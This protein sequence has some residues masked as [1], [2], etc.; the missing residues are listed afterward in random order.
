VISGACK[1]RLRMTVLR[2]LAEPKAF[3]LSPDGEGWILIADIAVALSS[4]PAW[5]GTTEDDVRCAF[6]DSPAEV[7]GDTV[8][9][10]EWPK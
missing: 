1:S 6:S 4:R 2:A 8:R 5:R 3:G 7:R 10:L 9:M